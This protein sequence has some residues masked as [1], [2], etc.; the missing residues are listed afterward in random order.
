LLEK[1]GFSFTPFSSGFWSRKTED[2]EISCTKAK[3]G[4]WVVY[5]N[6]NIIPTHI[7]FA[8][9]LQNIARMCQIGIDLRP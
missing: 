6:D 8:H 1:N 9:E 7:Q 5:V 2:G 4:D 3:G